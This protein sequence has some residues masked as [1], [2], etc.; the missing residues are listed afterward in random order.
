MLAEA[1]LPLPDGPVAV[2]ETTGAMAVD[3]KLVH[4]GSPWHTE[5]DAGAYQV[6]I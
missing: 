5:L 3:G 6:Q 1:G 4:A 2:T